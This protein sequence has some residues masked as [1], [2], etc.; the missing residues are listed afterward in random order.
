[1]IQ[2]SFPHMCTS[3][4]IIDILHIK[5]IKTTP[6]I[7]LTSSKKQLTHCSFSLKQHKLAYF[8]IKAD[9]LLKSN[10]LNYV[11]K[12]K[13]NKCLVSKGP[14]YMLFSNRVAIL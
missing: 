3:K 2:A 10:F 5:H 12:L 13:M 7:L 11:I 4:H 9:S 8:K 1:M 14:H 6:D